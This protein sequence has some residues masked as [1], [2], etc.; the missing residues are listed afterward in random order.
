MFRQ[1]FAGLKIDDSHVLT[2]QVIGL[3]KKVHRRLGPGFLESVYLNRLTI[4]QPEEVDLH[5]PVIPC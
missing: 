5:H 3:A 2:E 4:P 1:D